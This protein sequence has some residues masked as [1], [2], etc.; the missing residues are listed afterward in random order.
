MRQNGITKITKKKK[1]F[2]VMIFWIY[3]KHK[4][5]VK[6]CWFNRF[7]NDLELNHLFLQLCF[8][9]FSIVYLI[10]VTVKYISVPSHL[11]GFVSFNFISSLFIILRVVWYQ[12]RTDRGRGGEGLLELIWSVNRTPTNRTVSACP[13]VLSYL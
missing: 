13:C 7:D 3:F 11:N 1:I 8:I 4:V 2:L 12:R 9:L 10:K 5:T 6:P